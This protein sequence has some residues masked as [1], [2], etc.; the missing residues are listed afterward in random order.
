[1]RNRRFVRI[2]IW[3]TVLALGF[4]LVVSSLSVLSN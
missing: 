3:V 2:V 4:A 1:M